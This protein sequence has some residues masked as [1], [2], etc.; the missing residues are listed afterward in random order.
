MS[1]YVQKPRSLG[2]K[3]AEAIQYLRERGIYVLDPGTPKP[4]W[5]RPGPVEPARFDTVFFKTFP[6]IS[7]HGDV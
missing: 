7:G 1:I 2:Q 3:R 6:V 5:G 4:N